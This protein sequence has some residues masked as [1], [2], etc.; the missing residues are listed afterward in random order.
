M[1]AHTLIIVKG[2]SYKICLMLLRISRN[3][4]DLIN[5]RNIKSM[6]SVLISLFE[7]WSAVRTSSNG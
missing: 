1:Y 5:G 3:S 4:P 2:F 6:G 7:V